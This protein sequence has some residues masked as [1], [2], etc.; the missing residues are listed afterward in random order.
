MALVHW[1]AS[2]LV[3]K[4][5]VAWFKLVGWFGSMFGWFGGFEGFGSMFGWF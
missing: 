3:S 5:L 1:V 4:V 2:R